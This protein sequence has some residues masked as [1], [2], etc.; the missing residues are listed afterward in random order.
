MSLTCPEGSQSSGLAGYGLYIAPTGSDFGLISFTIGF[1]SENPV[2]FTGNTSFYPITDNLGAYFTSINYGNGL[3]YATV[4]TMSTVFTAGAGSTVT[5]P[6]ST[7][8]SGY[9]TL[10]GS[11]VLQLL[12]T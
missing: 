1:G 12:H 7:T 9:P 8:N 3:Q 6:F 2:N 4:Y 5:Y 11:F 10:A